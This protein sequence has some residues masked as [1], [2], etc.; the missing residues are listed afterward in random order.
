MLPIFNKWLP[1]IKAKLMT[2][3]NTLTMRYNDQNIIVSGV[4]VS[5]TENLLELFLKISSRINCHLNE[6]QIDSIQRHNRKKKDDFTV[7]FRSQAVK[8]QFMDAAKKNGPFFLH[9]INPA[10]ASELTST[11]SRIYFSH[12]L[13]PFYQKLLYEGK[14]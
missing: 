2:I 1:T 10:N 7:I 9:Q 4:C 13:T 3:S 12:D 5:S 11:P 8:N 14:Q 6:Q